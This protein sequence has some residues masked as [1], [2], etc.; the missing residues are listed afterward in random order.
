MGAW[1]MERVG[2]YMSEWAVDW[3]REILSEC[4]SECSNNWMRDWLNEWVND[5][6]NESV[7]LG[8]G[9]WVSYVPVNYW[10]KECINICVNEF[11]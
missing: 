8:V 4:G 2:K 3:M 11:V 10:V 5:W 6:P 7:K 1:V 9:E